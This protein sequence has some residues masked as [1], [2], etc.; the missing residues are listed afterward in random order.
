MCELMLRDRKICLGR[1]TKI[2]GVLNV[3]PDS[4]SD[5]G[6]FYSPE[7]ATRHAIEMEEQ[8]ADFL[9]IGGEST[10]PG[11][12]PVSA[13]EEIRRVRPVIKRLAKR[14]KI[15][16]S[17]DTYKYD[18]ACAALDEGAC[19]VNDIRALNHDKRMGKLIA[20]YKAGVVLMHMQGT[21][22]S[23]QQEPRYRA[24]LSDIAH[25]LERAAERALEAGIHRSR[26]VLDPG[27]GFGKTL[28]HNLKL[29]GSLQ[30][31]SKLK[32]PVLVGLSNKSFIGRLLD[33][34]VKDRLYGSLA[35]AVVAIERGAHILRVHE[36]AAHRQVARLADRVAA[37]DAR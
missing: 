22:E 15:P 21:P 34:A 35:G 9:D 30:T 26:I 5:G 2:M 1:E 32:F 25:F 20:R 11:A 3:T 19:I 12:R 6:L 36:V 27:F 17:I 14:V 18:T 31:F 28:E 16:I 10:R 8:G 37:C 29:L 23:M 24:V 13:K 7:Q 33:A 4:F